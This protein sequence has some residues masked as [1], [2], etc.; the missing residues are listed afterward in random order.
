MKV[1]YYSIPEP[2]TAMH[3]SG[4]KLDFGGGTLTLRYDYDRYSD[5][6]FVGVFRSGLRFR[7]VRAFRHRAESHC[8]SWHVEGAYDTL[9][10]I[11]GSEWVAELR[12]LS[13]AR[14][15]GDWEMHHYMIYLDSSGCYEIVAQS[16]EV[17]PEEA[18]AWDESV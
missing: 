14:K 8:T 16:W 6:H 9:V 1:A 7:A 5:D 3:S 13:M 18:G 11:E 12:T 17:L 2:S 4:A 15:M 10:E